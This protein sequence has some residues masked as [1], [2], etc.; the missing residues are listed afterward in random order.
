[1]LQVVRQFIERLPVGQRPARLAVL[2]SGGADSMALADTLRQLR[3]EFS[4]QLGLVHVNYGLRPEAEQETALV[5]QWARQHDLPLLVQRVQLEATG[6]LQAQARTVRLEAARAALADAPPPAAIALGHHADDQTETMLL[7]LLR[8]AGLAGASGM[9]GASLYRD[10]LLLR[11]LLTCTH[12][13]LVAY[14]GAGGVPFAQDSSNDS[15]AYARNVIR[16]RFPEMA[17]TINP[18]WQEH[19]LKFTEVARDADEVLRRRAQAQAMQGLSGGYIYI[20]RETLT[21][22]HRLERHY[23]WQEVCALLGVAAPDRARFAEL[24]RFV[25]TAA[26]HWETE[27]LAAEQWRGR[28]YVFRPQ[29]ALPAV[30]VRLQGTETAAGWGFTLTSETAG[31]ATDLPEHAAVFSRSAL[32]G[33]F[34]VRARRDGDRFRPAGMDGHS[35][36]LQDFL[37]AQGIPRFLRD[38]VPLLVDE[39]RDEI[40]WV[41]GQRV[42][43]GMAT[44][45]ELV[46]VTARAG[47]GA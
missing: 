15:D 9:Q 28:V 47:Q 7:H 29:C 2:V 36:K 5:E 6:N 44:G 32:R 20:D 14:C 40:I 34:T 46:R 4:F 1:M 10:V 33:P 42:A 17:A 25:F 45:G 41:V 11:P 43:E 39:G 18:A 21:K 23:W 8:G 37:P 13:Q 31:G 22:Y 3:T 24:E 38:R 12:A 19:L 35:Q 30:S 16:H 26:P 27:T